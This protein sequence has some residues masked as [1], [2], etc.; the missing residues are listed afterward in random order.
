[1]RVAAVVLAML[2]FFVP[3]VAAA[4][5]AEDLE[6]TAKELETKIMAPCCGGSPVATHYSAPAMQVK[7]EIREMLAAGKNEREILDFYVDKHGEVILSSPR[8]EGFGLVAWVGPFVLM[9]VAGIGLIAVIRGWK[10]RAVAEP[11]PPPPTIDP[12][13]RA[14]LEKELAEER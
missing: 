10:R 12:A 2:A 3:A 7:R 6:A 9:V 4:A 1:M 5:A 11:E 8:A 13:D 14:R